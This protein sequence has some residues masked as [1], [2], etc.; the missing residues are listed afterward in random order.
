[1]LLKYLAAPTVPNPRLLLYQSRAAPA[2]PTDPLR[3]HAR[4]QRMCRDLAGDDGSR[5]DHRVGADM[6]AGQDHAPRAKARAIP[7]AG[8][9][10]PPGLGSVTVGNRRQRQSATARENIVCKTYAGTDKHVISDLDPVPHHRLVLQGDPV[11]DAGSG[12]DEGMVPDVAVPPDYGPLHD[13]R[14]SPDLRAGPNLVAFAKRKPMNK[15]AG[16]R[17]HGQ[18]GSPVT[19]RLRRATRL[20][21]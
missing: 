6:G 4:Y 15:Y 13:V 10:E 11:A 1:M 18:P 20:R 12:F 16:R 9:H 3:W 21:A 17:G 2:D 7:D 19:L 8:S 14:E 5:S